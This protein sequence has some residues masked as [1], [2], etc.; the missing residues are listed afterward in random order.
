MVFTYCSPYF[1]AEKRIDSSVLYDGIKAQ[2][3]LFFSR[4]S[5]TE[6][7]SSVPIQETIKRNDNISQPFTPMS[8]SI[9]YMSLTNRD[10]K[11]SSTAGC[12]PRKRLVYQKTK[13]YNTSGIR[14]KDAMKESLNALN[15]NRGDRFSER[16]RSSD[17]AKKNKKKNPEEEASPALLALA[18]RME[19]EKK[20]IE[21]IGNASC[22]KFY[23][24]LNLYN[25]YYAEYLHDPEVP[26]TGQNDLKVDVRTLIENTTAT[27]A[28]D[29]K[30]I[31]TKRV[32]LLPKGVGWR[33]S[34][35]MKDLNM[36]ENGMRSIPAKPFIVR[37]SVIDQKKKRV[38]SVEQQRAVEWSN[39]NE[40]EPAEKPNESEKW[41]LF[42]KDMV[43]V[44]DNLKSLEQMN[45][46]VG[47]R[48]ELS[49][50]EDRFM[51]AVKE[52]KEGEVEVLLK[53]NSDLVKIRDSVNNI[54]Y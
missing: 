46:L 49:L 27:T 21:S 16:K 28:R 50:E 48:K 18:K 3:R 1:L 42:R 5:T 26:F 23:G 19:E 13:M 29:P 54:K 37:N 24:N 47:R 32:T 35:N 45:V 11:F 33:P 20:V 22:E 6:I 34:T 44:E 43:K 31:D 10:N 36:D 14:L 38:S 39:V 52:G 15:K 9:A 41:N 12:S 8:S 4:G 30:R 40:E 7:P 53:F 25:K 51:K 2:T 17:Q